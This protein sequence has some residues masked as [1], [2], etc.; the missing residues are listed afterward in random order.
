MISISTFPVVVAKKLPPNLINNPYIIENITA[1]IMFIAGPAIETK[2]FPFFIEIVLLK[3][4]GF[5]WYC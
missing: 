2:A 4:F 5:I 3:L 1:R